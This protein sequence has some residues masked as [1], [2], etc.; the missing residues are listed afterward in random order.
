MTTTATDD[1]PFGFSVDEHGV[2]TP[3]TKAEAEA[4][5][6]TMMNEVF[7]QLRPP[8]RERRERDDG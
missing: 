2:V 6:T 5:I 4:L 1:F 3:F 8:A 7:K